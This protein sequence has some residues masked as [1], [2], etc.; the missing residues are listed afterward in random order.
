MVKPLGVDTSLSAVSPDTSLGDLSTP[1]DSPMVSFDTGGGSLDFGSVASKEAPEGLPLLSDSGADY[2]GGSATG[3][4]A[5]AIAEARKYVGTMYRWGG[6]TPKTGFDCSGL[7]QWAL[8]RAGVRLPRVSFQ[9]ANLGKRTSVDK[10][11]PGDLVAWDEND[12][13]NG[14]DHIALYLGNGMILEAP[15]SGAKVR[16]RKVWGNPWGVH[17]KYP[18][19]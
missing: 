15:H 4:R 12:R 2:S 1:V 10:L 6:S 16:I 7:T 11:Q 19:E 13:N 3:G 14:A 8:G 9:Q 18:G 5:A 17:I